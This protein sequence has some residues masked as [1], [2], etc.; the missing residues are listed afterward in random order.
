VRGGRRAEIVGAGIAGLATAILLA[1]RGWHVCGHDRS[2][3]I[4]EIG[5]GIFLKNKAIGVR[6]EMGSSPRLQGAQC[7]SRPAISPLFLVRRLT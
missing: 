5:A 6:E 4:R 2:S 1:R 7:T 3:D